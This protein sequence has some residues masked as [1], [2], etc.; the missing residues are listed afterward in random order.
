MEARYARRKTELLQDCEVTPEIFDQL[1]PRLHHFLEP[2][3]S[4]LSGHAPPQHARTYVSGLLSD[5]EC[6]NVESI[7]YHFGQ[8]RLD[9]Q[10]FIGW[11][12]GDD[13]PMRQELLHQVGQQWGH[14][15][16]VWVVEPSAFSKSGRESVGVARQGCGR[17]GQVDN[18]QVAIYLGYVSRKGHTLVDQRLFL[19]KDWTREKA[20]L[21]KAG[22]PKDRRGYRTR[23]QLALEMVAQDGPSLPHRWLA[24]DDE[25]GCPY[26]FRRRLRERN[27]RYLLAVPSTR[28]FRIWKLPSLS[29]VAK[30][31]GPS[32]LGKA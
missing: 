17:L 16:G 4:S 31:V 26:W 8:D 6:Q 25:M 21:N 12:D 29:T 1:I 20:R 9:L 24:G 3:V 32:G 27:E 7:A 5:V 15:E 23:H 28:R 13:P 14:R 11:K 19:P 10:G 22:V 30:G 18:C 2:F